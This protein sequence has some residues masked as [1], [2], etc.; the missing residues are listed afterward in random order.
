VRRERR[1]ETDALVQYPVVLF[2][3]I[4]D[5]VASGRNR[6]L[7]EEKRGSSGVEGRKRESLGRH[8]ALGSRLSSSENEAEMGSC[9]FCWAS[10]AMLCRRHVLHRA[11]REVIRTIDV[12]ASCNSGLIS[13]TVPCRVGIQGAERCSGPGLGSHEI[14]EGRERHAVHSMTC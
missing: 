6:V 13:R 4:E 1:N 9:S 5:S 11:R 7:C 3:G 14:L 2:R 12:T 10:L 8:S